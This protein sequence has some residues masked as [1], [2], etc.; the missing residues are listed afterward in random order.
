LKNLN[1]L[2]N[3][4]NYSPYC[5]VCTGCGEDGCCSPINCHFSKDGKYCETYLK[6]LK[7]GYLMY[8]DIYSLL[9]DDVKSKKKIDE[10]FHKNWDL[11]YK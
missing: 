6:D 11:I 9:K 3:K 8:S 4:E 2:K 1:N 10:I 5:E 7:F